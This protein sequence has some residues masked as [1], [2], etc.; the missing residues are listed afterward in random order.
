MSRLRAMRDVFFFLPSPPENGV[1]WRLFEFYK[2]IVGF[3]RR[4][5]TFWARVYTVV[6]LILLASLFN[7]VPFGLIKAG[8][9]LGFL[10]FAELLVVAWYSNLQTRT[11]DWFRTTL[12]LMTKKGIEK[13]PLPPALKVVAEKMGK[14]ITEVWIMDGL[15]NAFSLPVWRVV[16][17]GRPLFER[18]SENALKAVFAHEL[19]HIRG[20][21][22]LLQI[23]PWLI[24]W[25]QLV[26]WRSLP[27]QML[28][29][30]GFAFYLLASIPVS[31]MSELLADR[32]AAS[33]VGAGAMIEALETLCPNEMRT[34]TETHPSPSGRIKR[35]RIGS[36]P[37]GLFAI[38][39]AAWLIGSYALVFLTVG[40]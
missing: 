36:V 35:L 11:V 40:S 28:V 24:L 1:R 2:R 30:A 29:I 31:W 34:L 26:L 12:R 21:H 5:N 18:L 8:I 10:I 16:V 15:D 13:R 25:A 3:H 37:R 39:I 33:L 6:G 4:F 27:L 22:N 32:K 14:D 23:L 20:R 9:A 19:A 17:F 38:W 7:T